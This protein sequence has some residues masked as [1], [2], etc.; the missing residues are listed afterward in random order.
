MRLL[1]R[2]HETF[3]ADGARGVLRRTVRFLYRR[4]VR[5]LSGTARPVRYHGVAVDLVVKRMDARVP[6]AWVPEDLRDNPLYEAAQ[7]RALAA[8]VRPGDDVVIVGGGWGVTTVEAAR[9]A[10]PTGRVTTFEGAREWVGRVERAVQLAAPP[11]PVEVVHAVVGQPRSL[12]GEAGGA[13]VVPPSALPPCD[14]LELDC[15]GAEAEVLADLSFRP[16]AILV[17]THGVFGT[18]TSHVRGL[19]HERGYVVVTDEPAAD[20][21]TRGWCE[22]NDVR[23]LS[24]VRSETLTPPP[25]R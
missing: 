8:H 23:V 19:L 21:A 11:A 13:R 20:D 22:A 3:D 5:P 14:V 16:R 9:R 7:M 12:F 6:A 4:F 17:E 15:E 1:N 18:P 25:A 24:A 10:G 2:L